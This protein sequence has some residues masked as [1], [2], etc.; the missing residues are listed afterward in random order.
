MGRVH[1][2]FRR[3]VYFRS[4][5]A[6]CRRELPAHPEYG[7][8]LLANLSDFSF[9]RD[10]QPVEDWFEIDRYAVALA[11]Q[12]QQEWLAHYARYAFHPVVATVQSFCS[13]DL[14]GFY[15]DIL[16]DRLYTSACDARARRAAQT[17][18]YHIAHGLLRMIAPFLSF[19]AE[20]AWRV[21]QSEA[22]SIFTQRWHLYPDIP[23]ACALLDTWQLLRAIRADV[24]RALE[25]ARVARKIGSSLQAHV[26]VRACGARYQA[27]AGLGDDL[28]FMLITSAAKVIEAR[29]PDEEGVT[30]TPSPHPKCA[31]CWHYRADVGAD[32]AH[33]ALCGR[34]I[35]N[36]FGA[37]EKDRMRV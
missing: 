18:L 37:G 6:S 30:V 36:L 21:F 16:K 1:R 23:D 33:P 35:Q 11:A 13:E 7:A 29:C 2:L 26:E 31:R 4:N 34:C 10:A 25:A 19:T 15:L 5:P 9:A 12:L 27:L 8:F 28:K 32:S 24:M 17:A 20:E 22:S 3:T 14:G